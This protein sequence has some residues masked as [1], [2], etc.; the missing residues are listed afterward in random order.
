ML[1]LIAGL[2]MGGYALHNKRK[3]NSYTV[4]KMIENAIDNDEIPTIRGFFS[5]NEVIRI[6][7]EDGYDFFEYYQ[8]N[9][10]E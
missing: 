6:M 7:A 8:I 5:V 9:T 3:S 1:G 2:A 10:E 4:A